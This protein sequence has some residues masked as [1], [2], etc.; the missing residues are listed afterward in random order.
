M[1]VGEKR[2]F[3]KRLALIA[4]TLKPYADERRFLAGNFYFARDRRPLAASVGHVDYHLFQN[5]LHGRMRVDS[6]RL[7]VDDD[8]HQKLAAASKPQ[9]FRL[10]GKACRPFAAQ[11]VERQVRQL[12]L[13]HDFL[14]GAPFAVLAKFL[15]RHVQAVMRRA[16]FRRQRV[17]ERAI[18]KR[19]VRL[20]LSHIKTR[21]FARDEQSVTLVFLAANR[22][23]KY[24][25]LARFQRFAAVV[26]AVNVRVRFVRVFDCF[27][28]FA[29]CVYSLIID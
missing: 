22:K 14:V 9:V 24:R 4:R 23:S 5:V 26:V 27:H 12:R 13:P 11:G 19:S 3:D 18:L 16:R 8:A 10:C 6:C 7:F 2:T 15:L 25:S 28:R 29:P 21:G 20:V 17:C 1:L